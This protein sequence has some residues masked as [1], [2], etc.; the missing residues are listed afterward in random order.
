MNL[1]PGFR[2]EIVAP[3]MVSDHAARARLN[4]QL[5][6]TGWV[7]TLG[8]VFTVRAGTRTLGTSPCNR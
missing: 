2:I 1:F 6:D 7:K 8:G 3:M 4:L 5:A